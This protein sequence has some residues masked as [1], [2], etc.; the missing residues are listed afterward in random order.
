VA[1]T[2]FVAPYSATLDTTT[3]PDGAHSVAAQAVDTA[4]NASTLSGVT[5]TVANAPPADSTAPQSTIP[6]NSAACARSAKGA[7]V[8]VS[9]TAT[10]PGAPP[11]SVAPSA[12]VA[13]AP[14]PLA[15]PSLPDGAHSVAAPAEDP[16]GNASALAGVPV[17]V[18]N[19]PPADTTAPQS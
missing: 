19:A 6:C 2:A 13:P 16:A 1:A 4:G 10:L 11:V 15:T 9:L 12:S 17:T 8:H 3:L 5:V 7:A 18:A 14:A